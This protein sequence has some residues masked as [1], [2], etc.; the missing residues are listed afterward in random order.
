[1][2]A[3]AVMCLHQ[4]LDGARP[5]ATISL[6]QA[7]HLQLVDLLLDFFNSGAISDDGIGLLAFLDSTFSCMNT[8]SVNAIPTVGGFAAR[9]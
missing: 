1:M 7:E 2:L 5:L 6:H 8:H 3:M 9:D 4:L